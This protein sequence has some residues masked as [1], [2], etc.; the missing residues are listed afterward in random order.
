MPL[1]GSNEK[2]A[3]EELIFERLGVQ[4]SGHAPD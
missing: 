3:L 2:G 4:A 1:P